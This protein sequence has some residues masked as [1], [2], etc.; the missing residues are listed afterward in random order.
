MF[1]KIKYQHTYIPYSTKYL[2]DKTFSVVPK[3]AN[4]VCKLLDASQQDCKDKEFLM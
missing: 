4:V 3:T 2:K 1:Q